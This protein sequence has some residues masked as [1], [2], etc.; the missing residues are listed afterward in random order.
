MPLHLSQGNISIHLHRYQT[1]KVLRKYIRHQVRR[2][3][4][5]LLDEG[6]KI[7]TKGAIEEILNMCTTAEYNEAIIPI[8]NDLKNNIISISKKLNQ[9]GMRVIGVCSKTLDTST[10]DFSVKDES[11]MTFYLDYHKELQGKE[12]GLTE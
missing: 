7:I 4:L 10:L 6:L 9:E 3:Y 2:V 12:I 1:N 5:Y 8:T 11:N